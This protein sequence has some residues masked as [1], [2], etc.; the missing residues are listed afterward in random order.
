MIE[1]AIA[2]VLLVAGCGGAGVGLAWLNDRRHAARDR[3]HPPETAKQI[4]ETRY[5]KGELD[6]VEFT[7]RMHALTYGPPLELDDQTH[8]RTEHPHP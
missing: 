6:H 5:A 2:I 8:I 4:L 7:R 3:A 1:S